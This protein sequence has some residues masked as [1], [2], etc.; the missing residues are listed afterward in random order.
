MGRAFTARNTVG[1][2]GVPAIEGIMIIACAGGAPFVITAGIFDVSVFL[3]LVTTKGL[4]EILSDVDQM[5]SN[6]NPFSEKVVRR[7]RVYAEDF[8]GGCGLSW[9]TSFGLLAPSGREY[10]VRFNIVFGF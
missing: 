1:F 2:I 6:S 7:V 10:G 5:V 4:S 8:K 9:G 3:A